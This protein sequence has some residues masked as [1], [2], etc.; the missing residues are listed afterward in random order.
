MQF[1]HNIYRLQCNDANKL[2]ELPANLRKPSIVICLNYK[3]IRSL[4]IKPNA[5][6]VPQTLRNTV[7]NYS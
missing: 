1:V 2:L 5:S 4:F 7:E 3:V 6:S